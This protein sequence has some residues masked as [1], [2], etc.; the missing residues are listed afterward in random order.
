MSKTILSKRLSAIALL[1]P[2]S[3]GVADVGTD[4]G[5]IP[6]WLRQNGHEGKIYATDINSGP[7]D[8]AREHALRQSAHKDISF[9]LCDGLEQVPPQEVQ[10]VVMAGMGGETIAGILSAAPWTGQG[11]RTLILQPMT[12]SG[13]LRLWLFENGYEVL[14]EQLVEEGKVYEILTARGGADKS[15]S[16]AELFTGHTDLIEKDELYPK[17]LDLL[18]SKFSRACG[19]LKSSSKHEDISRLRELEGILS[20]LRVKRENVDLYGGHHGKG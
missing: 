13:E 4:H 20:E 12:K 10:T 18:I 6:V 3:G 9:L 11:G 16:P 8:K 2:E 1:I 7:L 17:Q 14:S 19:G 15:Y 5:Y